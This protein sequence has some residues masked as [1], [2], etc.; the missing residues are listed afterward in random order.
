[1]SR[2]NRRRKRQLQIQLSVLTTLLL[3]AA[4]IFILRALD[5][6]WYIPLATTTVTL[7]LFGLWFTRRRRQ[8]VSNE[9]LLLKQ[10]LDLT[11]TEFEQRIVLLLRD[12]GWDWIEHQGGSGD[13]GVDVRAT[14]RGKKW[15]VQCKRYKNTVPAY[16]VRALEGVRHHEKADHALLVT[17]GGFGPQSEEWVQEKPIDLWDGEDLAHWMRV[18]ADRRNQRSR[19][20]RIRLQFIIVCAVAINSVLFINAYM[21]I[22]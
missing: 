21:S 1:M 5:P 10:A 14:Q 13:G 20:A 18:A 12:L 3:I 16:M 22:F 19:R 2:R 9:K 6:R 7:T 4:G 11:P 15:V 17:T 8:H